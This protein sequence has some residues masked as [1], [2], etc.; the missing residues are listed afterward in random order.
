MHAN[1]GQIS[2]FWIPHEISTKPALLKLFPGFRETT[3]DRCQKRQILECASWQA[4]VRPAA[5]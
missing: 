4:L 3:H 1:G 5:L 2:H